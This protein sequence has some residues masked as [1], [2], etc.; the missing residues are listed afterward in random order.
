MKKEEL[1]T[2]RIN[3]DIHKKLKIFCSENEFKIN[4]VLEKLIIEFI[5]KM[6]IKNNDEK[7]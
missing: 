1:K 4:N 2:I 3:K 6:M 5:E 7:C